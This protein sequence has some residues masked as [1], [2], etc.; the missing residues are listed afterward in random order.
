MS[1]GDES[2]HSKSSDGRSAQPIPYRWGVY[3]SGNNEVRPVLVGEYNSVHKLRAE[4]VAQVLASPPRDLFFRV[5]KRRQS[6]TVNSKEKKNDEIVT[7]VLSQTFDYMIRSGFLYGYV[8]SGHSLILLKI[9][10]SAASRLFFHHTPVTSIRDFEAR[11]S[12]IVQLATLA[13]LALW[14]ER[15]SAEWISNAEMSLYKW[16]FFPSDFVEPDE[17]GRLRMHGG[18]PVRRVV[19]RTIQP[20]RT[21]F[22]R[23]LDTQGPRIG[24]LRRKVASDAGLPESGVRLRKSWSIARRHA[25]SALSAASRWIRAVQTP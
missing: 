15:M 13:M 20:I 12:P 10:E 14:S 5:L 18:I 22:R 17:P 8:S 16:P 25:L 23:H 11:Q 24:R 9:E 1:A 2:R 21:M 4:A 19:S 6:K 3:K 7:Q